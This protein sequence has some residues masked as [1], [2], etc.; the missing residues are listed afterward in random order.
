M[1]EALLLNKAIVIL[2][3]PDDLALVLFI[4]L[5]LFGLREANLLGA[6]VTQPPWLL[7]S[8]RHLTGESGLSGGQ[9]LV[10]LS[11]EMEGFFGWGFNLG[12]HIC[13]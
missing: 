5:L 11:G 8:V 2:D 13:F 1:V 7:P 12:L 6:V 4:N 9:V 10:E 3:L